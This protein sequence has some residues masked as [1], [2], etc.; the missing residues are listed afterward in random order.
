MSSSENV[1]SDSRPR[2]SPSP[3]PSQ[4]SLQPPP[5]SA[6]NQGQRPDSDS[7][8]T[9]PPMRT[10]LRRPSQA[11]DPTA[12]PASTSSSPSLSFSLSP[13]AAG[14]PHFAPRRSSLLANSDF[15]AAADHRRR[16]SSSTV[17]RLAAARFA[18][19]AA[20]PAAVSPSSAAGSEKSKAEKKMTA[21]AAARRRKSHM[22]SARDA[23]RMWEDDD[24]D[25]NDDQ[26]PA[27]RAIAT[28]DS[29]DDGGD[30]DY[31]LEGADAEVGGA[32]DGGGGG[33]GLP[34][35]TATTKSA[36]SND[37]SNRH[38]DWSLHQ[39]TRA[40]VERCVGYVMGLKA[41][42]A[43][44]EIADDQRA[45][46]VLLVAYFY[47]L[48]GVLLGGVFG[49]FGLEL[50]GIQFYNLIHIVIHILGKNM[51]VAGFLLADLS[52][53][54]TIAR[55]LVRSPQG[56]QISLVTFKLG[57][58][59]PVAGRTL[60]RLFYLSLLLVEATLLTL[61]FNMEF[62]PNP[63]SELGA[64]PCI[65]PS[66]PTEIL[67]TD[68][69]LTYL[70]ANTRLP[71]IYSFGLPLVDGL[72]GGWGAWPTTRPATHFT[73][74]SPGVA[75]LVSAHCSGP[76]P[77]SGPLAPLPTQDTYLS[78]GQL[79]KAPAVAFRLGEEHTWNQSFVYT[80]AVTIPQFTHDVAQFADREIQI[81]CQAEV[82]VGP[83]TIQT[84]FVADEWKNSNVAGIVSISFPDPYRRQRASVSPDSDSYDL[85]DFSEDPLVV[86]PGSGGEPIW[87]DD[88][89]CGTG[90]PC[91]FANE[92]RDRLLPVSRGYANLTRWI[93]NSIH[94]LFSGNTTTAVAAPPPPPGQL[95]G[96]NPVLLPTPSP[97]APATVRC[98]HATSATSTC[99]LLQWSTT[100]AGTVSTPHFPRAVAALT[101][102]VAHHALLQ[103]D[104]TA[105]AACAYRT[106]LGRG[107]ARAPNPR[108]V[109]A[110]VLAL[111]VASLLAA[112][113]AATAAVALAPSNSAAGTA[114][115]AAAAAA[116]L[117]DPRHLADVWT[118]ARVAA[119]AAAESGGSTRSAMQGVAVR[120][121]EDRG[122]R[123]ELVGRLVI[124]VPANV[125]RMRKGRK[126]Q[127][128][129]TFCPRANPIGVDYSSL[130]VPV[131]SLAFLLFLIS[132]PILFFTW[133]LAAICVIVHPG[134]V[135]SASSASAPRNRRAARRLAVAPSVL[136]TLTAALYCTQER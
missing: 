13:A 89:G 10:A 83:A 128:P 17:F 91:R 38:S 75:Y 80:L 101:A 47:G 2:P 58:H 16:S 1:R 60:R 48:A 125:L 94:H 25:D 8:R 11:S 85:P 46:L 87:S 98:G 79:E 134:A 121:G 6:S 97:A 62:D 40:F 117:V 14:L 59:H 67:P 82:T 104:P 33:G 84:S 92:V 76:V 39:G 53:K 28:G 124:G 96:P 90:V 118:R 51:L 99:D 37:S 30:V 123:G 111:L 22:R 66:Y 15:S 93:G 113:V 107:A 24:V 54:A 102:A 49:V 32:G 43:V 45:Q 5:T 133:L 78:G 31:E 73:V 88:G 114:A 110:C 26:E 103:F 120:L 19:A 56:V 12:A 44:L 42:R 36:K 116:A 23:E 108:V 130:E 57:W 115:A 52:A 105:S 41:V 69:M 61:E 135:N 18:S 4:Q 34:S 132:P 100:P 9:A 127:A 21:A 122:S 126:A 106:N 131:N 63:L 71:N 3:P 72:V 64:F 95:L 29:S 65:P 50:S 55:A 119:L 136:A 7:G 68:G 74:E 112:A 86:E 35:R 109:A 27:H 129:K 77:V 70:Q 20:V 81:T